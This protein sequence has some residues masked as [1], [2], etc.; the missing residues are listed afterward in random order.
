MYAYLVHT[1]LAPGQRSEQSGLPH[2]LT[3]SRTHSP[4]PS[5]V[6]NHS[7]PISAK[8]SSSNSLKHD[9]SQKSFPEMTSTT[10]CLAI[11]EIQRNILHQLDCWDDLSAYRRVTYNVALTCKTLSATALDELWKNITGL[12]PLFDLLP[13]DVFGK[14]THGD[15]YHFVSPC[16]QT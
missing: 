14:E 12:R 15:H 8:V 16:P 3:H 2:A 10:R 9:G 1:A 6:Q 5:L 13:D 4:P 11:C 7:R